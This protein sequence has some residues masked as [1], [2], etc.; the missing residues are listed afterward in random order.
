MKTVYLILIIIFYI[1]G[2]IIGY[3]KKVGGDQSKVS[4]RESKYPILTSLNPLGQP[5]IILILMGIF[6][7]LYKNS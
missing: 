6:I 1:V 3:T 7:W 5:F 2:V 4:N